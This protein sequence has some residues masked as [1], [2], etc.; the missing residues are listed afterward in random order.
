MCQT[1]SRLTLW[2][3]AIV[4]FNIFNLISSLLFFFARQMTHAALG[5]AVQNHAK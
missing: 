2:P 4:R 5:L 1:L 3:L